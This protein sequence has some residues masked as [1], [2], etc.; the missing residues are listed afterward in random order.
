MILHAPFFFGKTTGAAIL[1][2]LRPFFYPDFMCRLFHEKI[3]LRYDE[4]II[5]QYSVFDTVRMVYRLLMYSIIRELPI[6]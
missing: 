1:N 3:L 6:V 5:S 2:D 4:M